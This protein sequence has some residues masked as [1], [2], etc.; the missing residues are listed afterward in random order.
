[1]DS[2]TQRELSHLKEFFEAQ[3]TALDTRNQQAHDTMREALALA[4]EGNNRRFD[5]MGEFRSAISDQVNRMISRQE[6]DMA[7]DAANE[8]ADEA[9][10]ATD[11]R[12]ETELKP[13]NA[14]LDT[15]GRPNWALMASI[16]SIFLVMVGGVWLVIGLK[17]EATMAPQSLAIAQLQATRSVDSERLRQ[18]ELLTSNSTAA[19][20]QSRA[21]RTQLN[22]RMRGAEAMIGANASERRGQ[23]SALSAKLVEVETQFCASDIIRNLMHAQDMRTTSIMWTKL[24]TN[25]VLP[26]DNSYYPSICNRKE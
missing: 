19:D 26:T 12:F 6:F 21:D 22:D 16:M 10:H 9:R 11:A 2:D 17:I 3:L 7:R 5:Q 4:R 8:K 20:A 1:M 23:I 25:S 15:V 24:F 13:I 18:L 14:R